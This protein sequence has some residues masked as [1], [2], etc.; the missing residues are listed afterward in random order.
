M[1]I[2]I[3]KLSSLGDVVQT[4]PVVADLHQALAPLGGCEID[5]VVEEAFAAIPMRLVGHK[6]LNRVIPIGQRRWRKSY[7]S[8]AT[9]RERIAFA[10]LLK[11]TVYDVVID[12]QG[13][14]KSALVAR[15]ARLS[16]QGLRGSFANA[17]DACSYEWP[18][19]WLLTH[20]QIMPRRIHAVERTRLLVAKMLGF[21]A[22]TDIWQSPATVAFNRLPAPTQTSTQPLV[23][24]THGTT[25]LDNEWPLAKWQQVAQALIRSGMSIVLPH[26]NER[27]LIFC[28][29]LRTTLGEQ[30]QILPRMGLS[31]L[32]DQMALCH[33]VVG[34]DSGLSHLAVA[35]NLPHVQIFSQDRAWRAGPS[36]KLH[37]V[38]IGGKRCPDAAEVLQAWKDVTRC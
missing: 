10:A 6:G 9:R 14:I 8:S 29:T 28:Q 22:Q 32:L 4:L 11:T 27:E 30:I 20:N 21:E 26:A 15:M 13:L 35:L 12:C 23:M 7:F 37:Q 36:G 17:S 31:D 16:A 34:V 24:F 18:V 5:W 2:L 25:R 1:K 3:V 19:K 33:S 38:A